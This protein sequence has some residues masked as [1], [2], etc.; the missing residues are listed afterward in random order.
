VKLTNQTVEALV[1]DGRDRVIVDDV[2][3]GFVLRVRKSG[4]KLYAVQ[5]RRNGRLH[6]LTLGSASVLSA[7]KAR[8]RAKSL[9]GRVADGE[10]V[11]AI[12]RGNRGGPTMGVLFED[13]CKSR[14]GAEKWHGRTE[15]QYRCNWKLHLAP[16]LASVQVENVNELDVDAI[17]R[18]CGDHK[19][20]AASALRLLRA[21][22]NFAEKKKRLRPRGSNP[23][24][25]SELYRSPRRRVT[26]SA[27]D[28][29]RLGAALDRAEAGGKVSPWIALALRL[30]AMTGAR[31]ME[32]VGARWAWYKRSEGILDL[33]ESKTGPRVLVLPAVAR[34]LLDATP[35]MVGNPYIIAGHKKGGRGGVLDRR[36]YV[37]REQA[38]LPT[39][40]VHDLRHAWASRAS[41]LN[42]AYSLVAAA[43]GH[44]LKGQTGEYIHVQTSALRDPVDK[45][46]AWIIAAMAGRDPDADQKA[47]ERAGA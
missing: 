22:L 30:I 40:R 20:A 8:R 10:D 16:R 24:D 9:L 43:L 27:D 38:G 28:Y 47:D 34:R 14:T 32:I 13:Y 1:P 45:V 6:R 21:L 3:P 42:I 26:L 19:G 12:R 11:A 31:K 18:A 2:L 23:V 39:L 17:A 5:Y 35:R 29:A 25:G 33:P 46:G 44:R 41:E 4:A 36:F 7:D 15:L 37:I